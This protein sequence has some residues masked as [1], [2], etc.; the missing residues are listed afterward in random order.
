VAKTFSIIMAVTLQDIE[1][2]LQ[3][4]TEIL[5]KRLDLVRGELLKKLGDLEL[6]LKIERSRAANSRAR[7]TDKIVPVPLPDGRTPA[8][9]PETVGQL[10]VGGSELAAGSTEVAKWN[11]NMSLQMI[12]QYE[13]GYESDTE[14][15]GTS[16]DIK[17]ARSS[18]R[19]RL[20]VA[21]LAGI[22][23]SQMV[24]VAQESILD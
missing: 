11:A 21:R 12:L 10:V 16:D 20:H 3:A 17:K 8:I 24:L 4:Q 23:P 19:R 6:E 1:S 18:R 5:T 22:T 2:A 13:P 9:F 7:R 14:A 15:A